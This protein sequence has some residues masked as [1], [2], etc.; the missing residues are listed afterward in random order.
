MKFCMK[1]GME[2]VFDG[3]EDE[4]LFVGPYYIYHH[5]AGCFK[6]L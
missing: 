3:T 1:L 2:F 5:F 6:S 4:K